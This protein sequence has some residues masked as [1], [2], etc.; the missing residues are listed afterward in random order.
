MIFDDGSNIASF[1]PFEA[2][3]EKKLKM[4]IILIILISL[5]MNMSM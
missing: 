1:F 2:L 4:L 3:P 5:N